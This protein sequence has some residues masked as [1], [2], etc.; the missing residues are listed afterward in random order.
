MKAMPLDVKPGFHSNRSNLIPIYECKSQG[1]L[2]NVHSTDDIPKFALKY[3]DVSNVM[4]S[5]FAS[6]IHWLCISQVNNQ[7]CYSRMLN[8]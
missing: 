1:N 2:Y 4:P 3:S 7:N 8:I 5:L 6:N